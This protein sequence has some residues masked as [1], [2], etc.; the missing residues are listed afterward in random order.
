MTRACAIV[1]LLMPLLTGA[2]AGAEETGAQADH[3]LRRSAEILLHV[4][5]AAPGRSWLETQREHI[6]LR[7]S[8]LVYSRPLQLGERRYQLGLTAKRLHGNRYGVGFEL[9]F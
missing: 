5:H 3:E 4:D 7:R 1:L 9:Q 2:R 8:G 6:H